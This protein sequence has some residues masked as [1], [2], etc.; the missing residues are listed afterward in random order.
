MNHTKSDINL[1]ISAL[2]DSIVI[3]KTINNLMNE[4]TKI[5]EMYY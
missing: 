1:S 3:N 2:D 4:D 5:E